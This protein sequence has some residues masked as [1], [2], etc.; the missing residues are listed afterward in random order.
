MTEFWSALVESI[1][2][3]FGLFSLKR[4]SPF[5]MGVSG[6]DLADVDIG[7]LS[8]ASV[9]LPSAPLPPMW[10]QAKAQLET[11]QQADPDFLEAAFLAQAAKTYSGALRAEERRVGKECHTTCRS[12]WSPYH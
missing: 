6:D 2:S 5:D 10:V 9:D 7:S 11:L 8:P 1:L 4:R 12:R 3:F